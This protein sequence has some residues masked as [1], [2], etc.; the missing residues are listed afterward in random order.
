MNLPPCPCDRAEDSRAGALW[1]SGSRAGVE[2]A[3]EG[4]WARGGASCLP[5]SSM[6][7]KARRSRGGV[8]SLPGSSKACGFGFQY[9]NFI[10]GAC[11]SLPVGCV[12]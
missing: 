11:K 9:M 5:A 1:I 7:G 8:S 6:A 12:F 3:C 4:L 2:L 10:I